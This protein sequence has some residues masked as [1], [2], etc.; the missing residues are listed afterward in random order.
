MT[1]EKIDRGELYYMYREEE[2]KW[3]SRLKER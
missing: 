3:N 1:K 2:K